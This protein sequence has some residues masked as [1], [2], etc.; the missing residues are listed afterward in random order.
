MEFNNKLGYAEF[1]ENLLYLSGFDE[2]FI[3]NNEALLK[4]L[5]YFLWEDYIANE[6]LVKHY[7]KLLTTILKIVE[8][9]G[10]MW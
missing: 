1:N 10:I 9:Y 2:Q 7:V 5:S 4:D 6:L 8:D 3:Q